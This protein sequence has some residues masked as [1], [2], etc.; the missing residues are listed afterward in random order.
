MTLST[1][2]SRRIVAGVVFSLVAL[3]LLALFCFDPEQHS[4]FPVCIL[5]RTTG[6][7]CPGCGSLRAIHQL[8]HGHWGAAFHLNPLLVCSLPVVGFMAGRFAIRRSKDPAATFC[9]KP[10]WLWSALAVA[11]V[12]GIVR[13]LPQNILRGKLN[14]QVSTGRKTPR[15]SWMARRACCG[16]L[17]VNV[18]YSI[19]RSGV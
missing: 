6:L 16:V 17:K 5:H 4:F 9:I 19:S 7:L 11:I 14:R 10:A 15:K 12:F 13:N 18:L 2:Q 8:L 3:S 1:L